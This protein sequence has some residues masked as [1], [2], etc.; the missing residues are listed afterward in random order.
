MPSLASIT[1]SATARWTPTFQSLPALAIRQPYAWLVV[2]GI[3]DIE[4]RSRRTHYR[5][6]VLIHASLSEN[7]LFTDSIAGLSTR[8]GIELPESYDMGGIVGIAEI[9]GCE[10]RHGSD[11]WF[12]KLANT[13]RAD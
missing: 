5:G 9:V 4:N 11:S 2:N 10:R 1:L 13:P 6:K 12:G 7:L 3:K 8:A